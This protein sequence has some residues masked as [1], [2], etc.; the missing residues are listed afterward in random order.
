[1]MDKVFSM[2]NNTTFLCVFT[3]MSILRYCSKMNEQYMK[4]IYIKYM[5][6]YADTQLLYK[7]CKLIE[8]ATLDNCWP[9]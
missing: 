9:K 3:S 2:Y 5:Q 8:F 1:M 7:V 6:F 4:I